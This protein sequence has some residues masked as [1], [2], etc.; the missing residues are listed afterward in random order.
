MKNLFLTFLLV[1]VSLIAFAGG[2]GGGGGGGTSISCGQT[3][4]FSL[5]TNGFTGSDPTTA[6]GSCGSCCYAGSDLDGDGDQDVSFSTENGV[7]YQYCNSTGSTM[8]NDVVVTEPNNNCNLQGAVFVGPTN[9]GGTLD[10]SNSEFQEYGSNPGGNGNGFSFTGVSVP[11]GECAYTFIDGYAGATCGSA[12]I[13]IVCPLPLPVELISFEGESKDRYNL[14]TWLTA[15]EINNDFFIIEKSKDGKTFEVVGIVDGAGNSNTVSKYETI[16]DNPYH[17]TSYYR[18]K[19][20]DYDGQTKIYPAIA[21]K[22]ITL[23]D[24]VKIYPNPVTGNGFIEFSSI[25]ESTQTISIYDISGRV[26]YEKFY[27][28]KK[29]N[30]K[31]MLEIIH[32]TKGMYFIRMADGADGVNLKFIKE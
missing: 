21:V 16:D 24:E 27:E 26:V 1:F 10:C 29:E 17:G 15:S 25:Q 22:V 30:N 13:S 31:L 9:G 32:L 28:V 18:L 5:G 11:D 20:T 14:L 19:Q 4:S 3:S 2:P 23:F 7:W 8:V 12:T 6:A